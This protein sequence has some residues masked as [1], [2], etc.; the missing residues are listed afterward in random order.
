MCKPEPQTECTISIWISEGSCY[1]HLLCTQCE[2][3]KCQLIVYIP[4][5]FHLQ[6]L[7][8]TK[9]YQTVPYCNKIASQM[10]NGCSIARCI[11]L[12]RQKQEE[13]SLFSRL[14]TWD[15][16][17]ERQDTRFE[18]HVTCFMRRE[19]GLAWEV[20]YI[21]QV[22]YIHIPRKRTQW[23]EEKEVEEWGRGSWNTRRTQLKGKIDQGGGRAGREEREE[24]EERRRTEGGS[25]FL[26]PYK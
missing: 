6:K 18:R 10:V 24:R 17:L 3:T 8:C 19:S 22:L 25:Q 2:S 16:Q 12:A 14:T 13:T 7:Y 20:S 4:T 9:L 15:T 1:S 26:Y 5:N 23:S 21:W 11:C